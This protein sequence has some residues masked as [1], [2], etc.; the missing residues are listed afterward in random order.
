[1]S[2]EIFLSSPVPILACSQAKV[3]DF[4]TFLMK[5]YSVL[6][7]AIAL[8]PLPGHA[9][10]LLK[11][12]FN[13]AGWSQA[14]AVSVPRTLS[15]TVVRRTVGT[16]DV[17]NTMQ[18]SEALL[19]TA[20]NVP[21]KGTWQTA[22]Q[23]GLLP[24]RNS[25]ANLGKLTLSFALS[26]SSTNPVL[27][28]IESFDAQK[29]RTGGLTGTVYPAAPN[30]LQRYAL[31]LSVLK[32]TGT[33]R[34]D[35]KAPFVQFSYVGGSVAGSPISPTASQYR[36]IV[37]NVNYSTPACYVRPT[38][39]D[40]NDGRS[41]TSA[42]ATPQKA[43]D[44][45][46]AGDIVLIMAGTYR[47]GQSPVATFRRG[48]TPDAWIVLKNYPGHKPTLTSTGWNIVS[49]TDGSKEKRSEILSLC[50]LEVRGLHIRGEGDVAKK[51]YPEAMNKPD[52]RTNSNGIAVDGRY[53]KNIPHHLRFADNL[54][55]YC[56]GQGLG[57]LSVTFPLV[58]YWTNNSKSD[59]SK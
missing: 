53:M 41:E 38:G 55:E 24:V 57:S 48:G 43:L 5:R 27:V 54:V 8:L 21:T 19:L 39:N 10:T 35:P 59:G 9:A 2:G 3:S 33:G 13:T 6:L 16:V 23:S 22:L 42:F 11:T 44:V 30:F 12:D 52:S 56:P 18:A 46:Q 14:K 29:R 37:D 20:G 32:P 58:S 17:A 50:Y 25:E 31:D 1:M 26:A 15:A 51:K 36:L 49:I 7:L 47:G 34:F 40:N 45:A 28:R 4:F